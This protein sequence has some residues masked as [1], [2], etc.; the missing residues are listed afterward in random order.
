MEFKTSDSAFAAYLQT[1]KRLRFL[2]L[3]PLSQ[4]VEIVFDDPNGLGSQVEIEFMSGA[5]CPASEYACRLKSL[6]KSIMLAQESSAKR[7]RSAL[8]DR[9]RG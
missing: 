1:S 6:R 4:R 7:I 3:E 5:E 9:R 2:R 8:G